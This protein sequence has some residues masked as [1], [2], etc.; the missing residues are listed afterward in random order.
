MRKENESHEEGVLLGGRDLIIGDEHIDPEYGHLG[1]EGYPFVFSDERIRVMAERGIN[2]RDLEEQW[3]L[4]AVVREM[5]LKYKAPVFQGDVVSLQTRLNP[6]AASLTFMHS[7][8]SGEIL[9]A[10]ERIQY[11][12][13]DLQNKP[14]RIPSELLLRLR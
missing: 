3:G 9:N 2:V 14:T 4:R 8:H 12:M 5:E 6:S 7:M 1:H 13:T 11:V 10:T